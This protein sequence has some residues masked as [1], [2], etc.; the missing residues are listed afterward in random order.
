MTAYESA[1]AADSPAAWWEL[2]GLPGAT[3]AAD[4][5]GNGFAGV[6]SSVTFGNAAG[7]VPGLTSAAFASGSSSHVLTGYN[8]ALAAVTVE[9]WVNLNSLTQS[10]S[11][12]VIANSHTD[13]DSHGFELMLAA[14]VPQFWV[15][16]GSAAI[17]T[18]GGSVPAAGWAYLAGTWD[19]TTTRL[20][21]NGTQVGSQAFSGSLA[22]GTATGTGIGYNPAYSGDYVNGLIAQCAVY[23]TALTAA[24]IAAHWQASIIPGAEYAGAL[25]T[26]AV[27]QTIPVTVG[28][29][30][31]GAVYGAVYAAA[32]TGGAGGGGE[33]GGGIDHAV[34]IKSVAAP[35]P[36]AAA[37]PASPAFILSQ[38]PRMH[39]QNLLTGAWYH[40]DVQGISSPLITWTLNAPGTFTCTLAPPRPDMLDATGNPVLQEWRDAIYLE[41]SNQIKFGGIVTSSAMQGPQW[42]LTA[43]EFSTYPNGMIYEGPNYSVTNID[44]LDA[45]RYLWGWLQA[46]PG[47]DL[48]MQLG[49]QK[50]GV[51]LGAQAAAGATMTLSRNAA[52]GQPQI[53]VSSAGALAPGAGITISGIPYTVR[54]VWA[55]SQ[56]IA[57]GHVTLT[58]NLGEAHVAGEPVAVVTPV[59]TIIVKAAA[60][61]QPVIWMDDTSAFAVGGTV[62]IGAAQYVIS[63]IAS[64]T[65]GVPTG[66]VT[67]TTNLAAA[68]PVGTRVTQVLA[69]TPFALYWYNS[70]DCGQEITSI[71]QEAVFDFRELHTWNGDRTG[72]VHQLVFGVPR[73]GGRLTGLRFAE[74]ENIVTA[75][76]VTRD[77]TAY[78]SEVIGLGAGTG[79]A[80]VRATASNAST[81]RL[82]RTS[83]YTDQTVLTVARM[84]MKAQ[85]QLTAMQNIDTVTSITVKNHPNAPFGSF[86]PGDDIPVTLCTGWRNVTIWS[87]ITALS[88]DPSSDLMILTLARSDS[89]TFAQETGIAGTI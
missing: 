25:E 18:T 28:S 59:T 60:A 65:A 16:T 49:T 80:E 67:L 43:T 48:Q 19:G 72:V 85:R 53:W 1:V 6:P 13:T 79:S 5:S 45:V 34:V 84:A 22:A 8:P 69:V 81:G 33:L 37:K 74:G 14:G 30:G 17:N 57:T 41:E 54:Q 73:L 64:N 76:S 61:G 27:T 52:A 7:A 71:R 63:A 62:T 20:Y 51:L 32:Y 42:T 31:G 39:A 38:M 26:T 21:V 11:P 86:A 4:S 24:R 78:A 55:T 77:G 88:Q 44:A 15:G 46:Q 40:R 87:R 75:A 50:S 35:V 3:T 2:A 36:S 66:Q 89:F 70:T 10:G 29:G 9:A 68:C 47:G 82:R 56:G 23:G 58:G 83:V 12:R